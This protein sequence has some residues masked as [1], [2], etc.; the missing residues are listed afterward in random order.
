MDS[1]ST[2]RWT[3]KKQK[4]KE[5]KMKKTK[6]KMKMKKKM[7]RRLAC[8]GASSC[9]TSWGG[10]PDRAR[11][12]PEATVKP[13]APG[14]HS[15]EKTYTCFAP[16]GPSCRVL[17]HAELFFFLDPFLR[18]QFCRASARVMRWP[19]WTITGWHWRASKQRARFFF[20]CIKFARRP[21]ISAAEMF[22]ILR[23]TLS[24]RPFLCQAFLKARASSSVGKLMKAY[25]KL[26]WPAP[27]RGR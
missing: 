6:M 4:M 8:E 14:L 15:A 23:E 1:R 7:K 21:W 18:E 2:E 17:L 20:N 27:L 13:K 9:R 3:K 16:K 24:A 25:P 11:A 12:P 5:M 19:S 10:R 22:M 26:D